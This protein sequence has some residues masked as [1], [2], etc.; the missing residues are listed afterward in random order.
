MRCGALPCFPIESFGREI[1][2]RRI[3]P[4]ASGIISAERTFD[5]HEVADGALRDQL[6]R[7]RAQDRADAL[8][9]DLDDAAGGFARFDHLQT[10][11]RGVRHGLFAV[12]IFSGVHRVDHDLFVPVVGNCGDQAIDFFVVEQIFVAARHEEIGI[13]DDFACQRVPAV[14][15]VGRRDALGAG[16]ADG[17]C[18]EAG[19]LHA[20]AYDA[21]AEAIAGGDAGIAGGLQASVA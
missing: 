15:Q 5:H 6:F 3:F 13:A 8:R 4:R 19:T 18:Q 7:F 2:W 14:V 16:K 20:D 1:E 21:E 10:V 17:R 11:G 9:A 12:D